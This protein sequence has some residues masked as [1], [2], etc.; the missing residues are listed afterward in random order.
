MPWP[1]KFPDLLPT[2][3][4]WDIIKG[5]FNLSPEPPTTI[6]KLRQCVQDA[7]DNISQDDTGTFMTVCMRE[8]MLALLPEGVYCVLM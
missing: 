4:V 8:Y 3:H 2:E 7:G 5:E 1:A 6:A